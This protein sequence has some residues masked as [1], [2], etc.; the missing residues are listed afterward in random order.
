MVDGK[1]LEPWRRWN[2]HVK[3]N[4]EE[5]NGV[6]GGGRDVSSVFLQ[7][8]LKLTQIANASL[9]PDFYLTQNQTML[10]R[11]SILSQRTA[12]S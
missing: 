11:P 7:V 6:R 12:L 2:G 5:V 1:N 3:L 8:P 4:P 10:T 9:N